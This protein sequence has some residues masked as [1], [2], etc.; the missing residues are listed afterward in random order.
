MARYM[1]EA[2][3]DKGYKGL[4]SWTPGLDRDR[5]LISGIF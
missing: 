4:Q 3:H 2:V 1:P 5:D